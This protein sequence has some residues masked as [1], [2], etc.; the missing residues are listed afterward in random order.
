MFRALSDVR[1]LRFGDSTTVNVEPRQSIPYSRLYEFVYRGHGNASWALLPTVSRSELYTLHEAELISELTMR[2]PEAFR[3]DTVFFQRLV[4]ARHF[5]LPTRLLD[6]TSNPL[7]ALYYASELTEAC[8]DGSFQVF[9]VDPGMIYS[10]DSDTVSLIANFT[11]LSYDQQ[12]ALLTKQMV[13]GP[14]VEALSDA[15]KD[16]SQGQYQFAM[17]RLIH[18]I[19]GEKPY[20]EDRIRPVDLFRVVLVKPE[21]SFTRL[22][23]HDGAFLL[24][25]FHRNLNPSRVNSVVHGAGRYK[26]VVYRVPHGAKQRI[27]AELEL[28]G[29]NE[30]SLK[31]DLGSTAKAV[32]DKIGKRPEPGP[33]SWL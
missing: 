9:G 18:F 5:D 19:A 6:V 33:P 3:E 25:A 27:R 10:F 20:W 7:T 15:E 14:G 28:V 1:G 12:Q 13:G 31:R 8:D 30:E 4:R 21:S 26:R 23:V 29:I 16:W 22:R 11:R 24:S 17:K 32:A 2:H